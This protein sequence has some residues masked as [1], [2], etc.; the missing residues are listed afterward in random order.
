MA[1]SQKELSESPFKNVIGQTLEVDQNKCLYRIEKTDFAFI[2]HHFFEKPQTYTIVDIIPFHKFVDDQVPEQ[3]KEH[4]INSLLPSYYPI[5]TLKDKVT[6]LTNN[7]ISPQKIS[8]END[9][10]I[11]QPDSDWLKSFF[12]L[13]D[14]A[15]VESTSGSKWVFTDCG[16]AS[17][18]SIFL[19]TGDGSTKIYI[20]TFNHIL[21]VPFAWYEYR[22]QQAELQA[23]LEKRRLEQAKQ[24][25]ELEKQRKRQALIKKYGPHYAQC[26]EDEKIELGMPKEVFF[27]IKDKDFI[28]RIQESLVHGVRVEIY[29]EIRAGSALIY[30]YNKYDYYRF[31]NGKLVSYLYD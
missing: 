9:V 6:G 23:E 11:F 13:Y 4:C 19:T 16:I 24:Q 10:L 14:N 3:Y 31:E 7:F 15:E 28:A 1:F 8:T 2:F 30:G 20:K 22:K 27:E 21:K 25:A 18:G 5:L 17:S 26:I 12:R 29:R